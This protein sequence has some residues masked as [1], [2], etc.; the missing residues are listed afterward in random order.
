MQPQHPSPCWPAAPHSDG[1]GALAMTWLPHMAALG[2]G[3]GYPQLCISE[4]GGGPL[5]TAGGWGHG[6]REERTRP[7]SPFWFQRPEQQPDL[8]DCPRRL[9]GAALTELPV[10]AHTGVCGVDAA[11]PEPCPAPL[12]SIPLTP[13][14]LS[15]GAVWQQ[16]HRPPQR[17]LRGTFCP[18]ASVRRQWLGG[19]LCRDT[20]K[21]AEVLSTH[22]A[23]KGVPRL[24]SLPPCQAPQCQQDQLRAGRRLPGLAEP[25]AALTL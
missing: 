11:P 6:A 18:A 22:G 4:A 5:D 7:P 14:F 13:V 9:P 25:L 23:V 17:R 16:D 20:T 24:T 1:H 21:Q 8:G 12:S 2:W 3:L 19:M 15:Q 10:S